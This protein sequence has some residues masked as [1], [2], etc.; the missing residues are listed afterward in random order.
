M[1]KY[2]IQKTFLT[3]SSWWYLSRAKISDGEIYVP[4]GSNYNF[5]HAGRSEDDQLI[6]Y[7]NLNDPVYLE[8]SRGTSR[9]LKDLEAQANR[10]VS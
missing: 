7:N 5:H 9:L 1:E 10:E 6:I 3:R 4:V 8:M 2:K